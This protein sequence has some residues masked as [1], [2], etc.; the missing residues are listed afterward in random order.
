MKKK[1]GD[2][3]TVLYLTSDEAKE[4]CQLGQAEK[5]CPWLGAGIDGFVCIR[6]DYPNNM[7]IHKRIEEG[8]MKAKGEQCDWNYYSDRAE[9]IE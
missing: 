5:C 9:E 4:I 1:T 8:T 2:W 6:M 7:A 3:N